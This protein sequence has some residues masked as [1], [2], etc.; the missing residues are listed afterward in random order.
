M[1]QVAQVIKGERD[2]TKI[3]G[4]TGPLVYPAGHVYTYMGLYYLTDHGTNIAV[5][6]WIFAGIYLAT[7]ATVMG[8]YW[9]AKVSSKHFHVPL[10]CLHYPIFLS[11][12]SMP[13][14]TRTSR[15]SR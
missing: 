3:W 1:E 6:Q 2:Y 15:N 4:T 10:I 12:L 7:L 13:R 14:C 11:C 8:C 5:A 9:Q